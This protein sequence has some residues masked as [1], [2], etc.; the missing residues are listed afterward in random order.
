M[1]LTKCFKPTKLSLE[2]TPS[3]EM[4]KTVIGHLQKYPRLDQLKVRSDAFKNSSLI[5]FSPKFWSYHQLSVV[6]NLLKIFHPTLVNR[7]ES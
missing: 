4:V 3:T 2:T 5:F 6:K 1:I 7:Y